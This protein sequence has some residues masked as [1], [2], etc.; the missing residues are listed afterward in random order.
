MNISGLQRVRMAISLSNLASLLYSGCSILLQTEWLTS[1]SSLVLSWS[2]VNT[3]M[4]FAGVPITVLIV[5]I[6]P[7]YSLAR[8]AYPQCSE[9]L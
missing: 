9:L 3:V 2:L 4:L 6:Y 5:T 1:P 7:T 8:S